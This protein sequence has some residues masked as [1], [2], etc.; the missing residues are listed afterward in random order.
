MHARDGMPPPKETAKWY[1]SLLQNGTVPET[2]PE[3]RIV[4]LQANM[5]SWPCY[6]P[7]SP[8]KLNYLLWL[9]KAPVIYA[10]AIS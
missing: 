8:Y 1:S 4:R 3:T 10:R 5:A 2:N 6:M 7:L 9:Y